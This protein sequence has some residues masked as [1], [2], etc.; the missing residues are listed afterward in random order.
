[1]TEPHKWLEFAQEDLTMARMALKEGIS[2]Q[3]CFHAQ[4]GVE[5]ALKGFLRTRQRSIPKTH[6]LEELLKFCKGLDPSF[7]KLKECCVF[8]DRYYIPTRYPDALP[9]SLAEGLPTRRDAEKAVRSLQQTLNWIR[10]KMA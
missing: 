2:N 3:A 10:G 4:Q 7:I 5:K 6:A 1:M 9:G 8:L